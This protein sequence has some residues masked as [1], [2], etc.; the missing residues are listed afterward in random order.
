MPL[1]TAALP[2]CLRL[3]RQHAAVRGW[4]AGVEAGINLSIVEIA[5]VFAI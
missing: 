4:A 5:A 2:Q 3:R 1:N